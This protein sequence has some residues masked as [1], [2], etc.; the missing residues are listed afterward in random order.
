MPSAREIRLRIK[1][2]K[3]IKQ[4]TKAMEMVAAARLRRAQERANSGKPYTKKIREILSHVV[5]QND[6]QHP[7]LMPRE[8]VE[9]VGYLIISADKGLAGS[10]NSNLIK[11]ARAQL[12]GK[13]NYQIVTVG[14]KIRDFLK[15]RGIPVAE[16]YTGFSE[17]PT[18]Q[19]AQELARLMADKFMM[20]EV[21]EVYVTYTEF[22]SPLNHRPKTIKL[23]PIE[24]E[25]K[26][27]TEKAA[28]LRDDREYIFE[29][30]AEDVLEML[31]PRYLETIVYAALM[32]SAA[33]ELGARMTAMGSATDNAEEL[34]SN[35]VLNYNK[36]RQASITREITEIVGGAEALK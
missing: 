23:L 33:S 26:Q 28:G 2:V 11:E 9:N 16:E 6:I 22:F 1:S 32:Q 10:Y 15:R 3:N 35:L 34:I 31:V 5:A 13:D 12:E 19:H 8:T 27:E 36:V 24:P 17:K 4:I 7:L 30:A 29:P 20:H 14:R 18:Y 21:D 25:E